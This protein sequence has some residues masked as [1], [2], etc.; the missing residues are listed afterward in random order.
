[1]QSFV[2][3]P[4]LAKRAK[5]AKWGTYV[6]LG[7]LLIGLFTVGRSPI[8]AYV[9]MLVGLI[10]ATL[11]SYLGSRY[12]REPRADQVLA[13]ELDALDKRYALY[14]FY[15]P[16]DHVI[17]SHYGL[18]AVVPRFQEGEIAYRQGRWHHKSGWRKVFQL[19][20]EPALGK[21]DQDLE[22]EIK[23]V[24]EWI[25]QAMPEQ[26]VPVN[27]VVAFTSSRVKLDISDAPVP[28]MSAADLIDYMKQGLK[29]QPTLSTATQ[30]ELRKVLDQ[31]VG[32][33]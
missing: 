31:V 8:L 13:R 26:N 16:S 32:E 24:K 15:L 7:A 21:P 4:F 27:G 20:G 28:A 30:T 1:M 33:S 29:G 11:S 9:F 19:F 18:T 17:V 10:A 6:G 14:N 3:Q 5:W 2:N 22:Q 25:D 23:A 12:V